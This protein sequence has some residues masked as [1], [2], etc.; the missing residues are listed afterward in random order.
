MNSFSMINENERSQ[1]EYDQQRALTEVCSYLNDIHLNFIMILSRMRKI[2]I[3]S[4]I[5]NNL[6]CV[7]SVLIT[8]A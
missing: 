8:N 1:V 3:D 5:F 7:S 2:D 4:K 6:T